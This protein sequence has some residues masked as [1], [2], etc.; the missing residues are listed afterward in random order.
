M[1]TVPLG[2]RRTRVSLFLGLVLAIIMIVV[3]LVAIGVDGPLWFA[4]I[5]LFA[6]A[7]IAGIAI[8]RLV[9]LRRA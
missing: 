3:G 1:H 7:I 2:P 4:L 5:M 9:L 8:V 6:G